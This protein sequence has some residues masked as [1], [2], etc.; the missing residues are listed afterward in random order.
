MRYDLAYRRR[1]LIGTAVLTL[2]TAGFIGVWLRGEVT[3]WRQA[4]TVRRALDEGHLDEAAAVIENWLKT[5]PRSAEAHYLRA[6]LAWGRSDFRSAFEELAQA[7]ALDYQP[8][9]MAGLRGLLMARANQF[10]EAEPL[11]RQALEGSRE[12]DP[13]VADVLTRIYLSEF[14]LGR[15]TEVLDRWLRESPGDARPYLLKAEIGIRT[16]ADPEVIIAGYRAALERDPTFDRAWLGMADQLRM[17]H[18]NIEAAEAYK[19][20]LTRKPDD[21]VGYL[22]A[23]RNALEM[24]EEDAAIGYLDRAMAMAPQDPVVLGARAW[25]EVVRGHHEAALGYFDRAVKIDPFDLGNREQRMRLLALLGKKAEA[26]AERAQVEQIRQ[27]QNRFDVLNRELQRNPLDLR[28]RGQA[29]RWLMDHGHPDEAVDWANLVLRSAPSDPSMNRL[30]ADYYR[31][32]GNL[33]LANFHEAHAE[34]PATPA[35]KFP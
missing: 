31:H 19:T 22:G 11:L 34:P 2:A 4:R 5:E 24:G 20:Y 3:A 17:N 15:A 29:A 13:E 28:L 27:D 25:A 1:L 32:Q 23:G 30:L 21:P 16:G 35:R 8:Q 7:R 18:S 12:F 6:R 9:A 26:D 14:R 10:S 33:G